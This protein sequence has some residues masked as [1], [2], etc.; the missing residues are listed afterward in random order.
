MAL[1]IRDRLMH[2]YNAFAGRTDDVYSYAQDT[3]SDGGRPGRQRSRSSNER[4]IIAAIYNRIGIDVASIDIMHVRTDENKRF[5]EEVD[6]GLNACLT[7]EANLDQ[8]ASA[9]KQD[10]AMSLCEEGSIAIVPVDTSINPELSGGYDIK[11]MRVGTITGWLPQHIRTKVYDERSGTKKDLVLSKSTCGIVENPFYSVMNEPNSTLQRLIRKLNYLDAIDKQSSSGKLDIIIQLPYVIKSDTRKDQAEKRRKALEVQMQGSQ[12]GIGYIDGTEKITQLNRPAE[13]NLLAQ[14]QYLTEMLYS[15]LG[16]TEGVMNGTAD[17]K[18]M[19]NY[20]NRTIEPIV[21]AIA[22]SMRR[23][24]ITKTG[25]TQ[26]QTIMYFRDPFKFVEI[27]A[28]AEI[29]DKFTRNEIATGNEVRSWIGMRPSKD[30]TADQL[31]NKNIPEAKPV[32]GVTPPES[33]PDPLVNK[34]QTKDQK[35]DVTNGSNSS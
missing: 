13:N 34:D 16:I 24:F 21:K 1:K 10:M 9:F 28:I 3:V 32:D 17:E 22:E 20:Y 5:L 14:V 30:K 8:A 26:G 23:T 35:G 7:L 2:A 15:Q 11:S 4:S 31:R 6:S 27:S 33:P 29:A 19:I 25:R 12:Y 18:T